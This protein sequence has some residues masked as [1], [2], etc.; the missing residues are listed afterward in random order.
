MP[1]LVYTEISMALQIRRGTDAQRQ[2]IAFKSGELI[3]TTDLKD[4]WVGDGVTNGGTQLSP[5][6]S[7]NG[8]TGTVVLTTDQVAQGASGTKNYYSSTQAKI[9]AGAAIVAGNS[10]NTGITF[11]YNSG[12]NV[13]NAV[14]TNS[15]GLSTVAGDPSPALGG[16]LSLNSRNIGGTGNINITGSVTATSLVSGSLSIS[17]NVL[18]S[19]IPDPALVNVDSNFQLNLGSITNPQTTWHYATKNFVVH[20]GIVGDTDTPPNLVSRISRGTLA[21]PVAV[22]G[23]DRLI[24]MFA[25]GYDGTSYVTAGAFGL[26]VDTTEAVSTGF[27]PGIFGAITLGASGPQSMTFNSRGVL[28]VPVLKVSSFTVSS[29][30]Q[31]TPAA[32]MIVLDGTTFKGYNGSAWVNLN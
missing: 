30:T 32:G 6:K 29:Q 15:G 26:Q 8:S 9:D 11:S 28:S 10:G 18:L 17:N 16:N 13:I 21:V 4:M 31:F 5:V 27:V 2:T 24:K 22:A 12:T 19:S 3:Y 7:V 23:N 20:T 1:L 14:V 25:Q